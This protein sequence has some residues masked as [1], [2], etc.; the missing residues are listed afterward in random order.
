MEYKVFNF[1]S[2]KIVLGKTG[3]DSYI[4]YSVDTKYPEFSRPIIRGSVHE[5]IE[6]CIYLYKTR[7]LAAINCE[8]YE[9]PSPYFNINDGDEVNDWV[10]YV[11]N[12]YLFGKFKIMCVHCISLSTC[13]YFADDDNPCNLIYYDEDGISIL[14]YEDDS[15]YW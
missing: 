9:V 12:R 10:E 1:K 11:L 4:G 5:V 3:T 15:D 8:G 6:V 2:L 13:P 14:Q 7:L